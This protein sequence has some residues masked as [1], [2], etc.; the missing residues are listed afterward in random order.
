MK[1]IICYVDGSCLMHAPGRPGGWAFI[2]KFGSHERCGSDGLAGTTNNVMEL[3]AVYR[4]LLAL[5]EPCEIVVHTDSDN[6]IGWV[7][8][9]ENGGYRIKDAKIVAAVTRIRAAVS[10]GGHVLTFEKVIG[11]SGVALNER[12]DSMARA[13][14]LKV[15]ERLPSASE[16]LEALEEAEMT[17]SRLDCG[18]R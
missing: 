10:A 5:K 18:D 16:I 2:L 4:A 14:A 6:V 7:R 12:C 8:G 15:A 17:R 11:H 9:R 13:A 1:K 3:E